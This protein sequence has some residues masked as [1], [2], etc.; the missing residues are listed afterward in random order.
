[1]TGGLNSFHRFATKQLASGGAEK[2][3]DELYD[4]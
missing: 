4:Q 1:M 2:S 3:I